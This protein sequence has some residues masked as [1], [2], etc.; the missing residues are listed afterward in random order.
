MGGSGVTGK[1]CIPMAAAVG[2][3]NC[4]RSTPTIGGL[5]HAAES[6]TALIRSRS[7]QIWL[8]RTWPELI[9][10]AVGL[11][12]AH[13]VDSAVP[14]WGLLA[15][16]S[17]IRLSWGSA[18]L[19]H[20]AGH[21]LVRGLVDGDVSALSWPS[22]LEHRSAADL[23]GRL[24]PL[25][26]I[27]LAD[28]TVLPLPWLEV[29][30]TAPWRVRVK[31]AGGLLFN[32]LAI[33]ALMGP[34][35]DGLP[36]HFVAISIA[37]NAA[38]LL[39]SGSDWSAMLSGRASRLHCG[40]FGLISGPM[41][42][43][44]GELLPSCAIERLRTMGLQTEIRGAQAAG[45]L[46]LVG[47]RQGTPNFVAH[48]LVNAKR[49][50]LT[51]ALEAGFL[52]CRR[53]AA[54]VGCRP[55]TTG[56]LAAY[57]YRFGT[58]S[59]PALIETHWHSWCPAQ[60]RLLWSREGGRWSSAWLTV[61]HRI[62]HNGDFESYQLA[63]AE[64]E[65]SDVGRWLERVLHQ[66][67]AAVGDSP[68]I[69]GL[70]DLLITQGD[71]YAAVRLGAQ[72]LFP[73]DAVAPSS[74]ELERWTAC[75]EASFRSV[76]EAQPW[77]TFDSGDPAVEQLADL[78][79]LRLADDVRLR[80]HSPELLCRWIVASIEAFLHN[81]PCRAVMQFM[82]LA[83]GSFGLVVVSSTWPDRVVLASLGQPIT[84]GFDPA[85]ALAVYASEPAAVD[86]V[87]AGVRGAYR[88]DL[89]QN[90][91]E[92]A[93]LAS[94]NLFL[95][96][97]SL[98]GEVPE[99]ER[100]KRRHFYGKQSAINT[101]TA[102]RSSGRRPAGRRPDLVGDDLRSIPG[103]LV[104]IHNDWIDPGSPNRQSAEHLAQFLMAKAAHLAQ[105]QAVLTTMGM[106]PTLAKS[107]HVD[108]LITGVENSL[109]LGEQFARD[110]QSLMP[111][112]SVRA[113]SAN[114]VLQHLQHDIEA[115]GFARQSIVLVLTHSGQTFA[116]RQV[117]ETCDLLVRREVIRELFVLTGEPTS[118]LGSPLLEAVV[119]GEPF[120]RRLFTT[121][122]GRRLAEPA[123]ATVAAMHQTLTE[124][125][126]CLCRQLQQAFPDQ[127]PLGV[128]LQPDDLFALET[129]E[130]QR[131]L[132]DVTTIVG[133]DTNGQRL[134]TEVSR[135]LRGAG[136]RWALHVLESPAAWVI[137]A[138][139]ILVSVEFSMP[140]FRTLINAALPLVGEGELLEDVLSVVGLTA[141][142]ALYV[143]GPW[144]WTVGLR[145]IQGRPLL[146]RTGRR[147][148]VI[149]ETEG[150]HQLLVNYLSKLFALSF[151]IT[152]VDVQGADPGDHFLHTQAHRVVRGT[153]V[154]LGVPDG[155]CSRG[156]HSQE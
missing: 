70:M 106:D 29:G 98:R 33:L 37:A 131:F 68:K 40:N 149:G 156:L 77:T 145:L 126:F 122:A 6:S 74:A 27:G 155:R 65:F 15:L 105:K 103:L 124:L 14:L 117:A 130:A 112:L 153:L 35:A 36:P 136:R 26:P 113:I 80:R 108:L 101:A 8:L 39:A 2:L 89:D 146:A 135:Q 17:A 143:F 1:D 152:A 54:R 118:F 123:T 58:S 76:L 67:H 90:A 31:A 116:S 83:R 24:L 73:H 94:A 95:H 57:H 21:T 11:G 63:S 92:V 56:L 52:R 129:M 69:A 84:V 44:P 10:V 99:V 148:V 93:V 102:H 100:L 119:P 46:V 25:A 109:W 32:L 128:R 150:V 23:I 97:L 85:A 147:T 13:T 78:I 19:F 9:A 34:L 140:L 72:Q 142:A 51:T 133:A 48:K 86:A 104:A 139:Y 59:P 22:M 134:P 96:S 151:G 16:S 43:P 5:V 38:L 127:R 87:L 138:L 47:D 49:G 3:K 141:D 114:T 71:W 88:I 66:R 12:S 120:C 61:E 137:H 115:L 110:L 7:F 60:R 111:L 20:G 64:L 132:E 121:G 91:G 81:D 125:L 53:Q 55:L 50:H 79:L 75:F 4:G 107:R 41:P 62:T 45:A 18:E 154:Y 30:A 144:I 82:E 42:S 28:G